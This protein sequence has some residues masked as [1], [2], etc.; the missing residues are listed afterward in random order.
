MV[1]NSSTC[2]WRKPDELHSMT[3]RS[4]Q[5]KEG[6]SRW[7]KLVCSFSCI[8]GRELGCDVDLLTIFNFHFYF[9]LFWNGLDSLRFAR[10]HAPP[11][12]VSAFGFLLIPLRLFFVSFQW[13]CL[14]I[15][16]LCLAISTPPLLFITIY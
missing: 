4:L 13:S 10:R 7:S 16:R 3:A 8:S 1:A 11:V 14:F 9:W 5:K 15:L 2:K 12:V 6:A